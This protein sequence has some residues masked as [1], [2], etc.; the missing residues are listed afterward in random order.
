MLAKCIWQVKPSKHLQLPSFWPIQISKTWT[1]T[2][3][4]NYPSASL[5]DSLSVHLCLSFYK[6]CLQNRW[7]RFYFLSCTTC[8]PPSLPLFPFLVIKDPPYKVKESGYAGFSLP[9]DIYVKSK[10]EPRKIKFNYDLTLQHSGPPISNI[11]REKY[12][13]NNP[14]ED[15][16]RNLIKGGGV[17]MNFL[18]LL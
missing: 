2:T 3:N 11:I 4:P 13:F 10:D 9:I 16:R 17:S 7:V 6:I 1:C 14:S 12:I 18:N 15:F 8:Y 5:F